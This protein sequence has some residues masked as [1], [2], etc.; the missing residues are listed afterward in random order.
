MERRKGRRRGIAPIIAEL[1]LISI[2]LTLGASLSGY[3]FGLIG[4]YTSP[5]EVTAQ[6]ATCSNGVSGVTC[7]ITLVNIGAGNVK[8][9]STC[10]LRAAGTSVAGTSTSETV[11]AGSSAT[12]VQCAAPGSLPAGG[13]LTGSIL[14]SNGAQVYFIAR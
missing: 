11:P 7:T 1:A 6:Q 8:T 2:T 5:A 3:V 14:L 12:S 4:S 9:E 10:I 13:A